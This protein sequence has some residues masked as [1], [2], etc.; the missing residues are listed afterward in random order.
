MRTSAT[1]FS[2]A[3]PPVHLTRRQ[4]LWAS[5][6]VVLLDAFWFRVALPKL[7]SASH[8]L[9][10]TAGVVGSL[11]LVVAHIDV[12]WSFL[13]PAD[14]PKWE[15]PKVLVSCFF[16]GKT[17]GVTDAMLERAELPDGW[18]AFRHADDQNLNACERPPCRVALAKHM[19][20]SLT[21]K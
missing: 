10:L 18:S 11:A 19:A 16:C 7:M 17:H 8:D 1:V 15:T 3:R 4:A 21:S 5:A 14:G 9:A 6:A 13:D 20:A 12:I 2:T